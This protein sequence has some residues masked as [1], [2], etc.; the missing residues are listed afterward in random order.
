M[1]V[2][3]LPDP[4][5]RLPGADLPSDPPHLPPRLAVIAGG[6]ETTAGHGELSVVPQPVVDD[7][8]VDA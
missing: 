7:H 6:A 2:P 1:D 4:A 3:V 8:A 5:H